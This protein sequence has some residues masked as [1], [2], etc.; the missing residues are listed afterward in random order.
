MKTQ[1]RRHP[2]G[3]GWGGSRA[4]GA[5]RAAALAGPVVTLVGVVVALVGA[6]LVVTGPASASTLRVA[7]TPGVAGTLKVEGAWLTAVSCTSTASCMAVGT[8]DASGGPSSFY[9]LTERWNGSAWSYV[10]SPTP[11]GKNGGGELQGVSCASASSCV[12]VGVQ[13]ALD[14]GEFRDEALAEV[15]NGTTWRMAS[16]P[17]PA[18]KTSILAGV[19]CVTARNCFAVG[20]AGSPPSQET[21]DLA[22]LAEQWNGTSWEIVSTPA[23]K[24]KGG[25]GLEAVSCASTASCMTG[26]YDHDYME[27]GNEEPVAESWNGT[28]W[29]QTSEPAGE[30]TVNGVF[31]GAPGRC[32]AVGAGYGGPPGTNPSTAAQTWNGT[33]WTVQP[34][35][36]PKNS[37]AAYL[38]A[39]SCATPAS[40]V[41]TGYW[42]SQSVENSL[43][44]AE[45]WNGSKWQIVT[46][47]SPGNSDELTGVACP[48][49]TDCLAVGSYVGKA[50]Q[51]TLAEQWNGTSWT[52]LKTPEGPS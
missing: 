42:F 16:V 23:L 14:Q 26:G 11:A 52:V 12:A 47:P 44:L 48:A 9:T 4:V 21:V 18:G 41:A 6:T 32:T 49:A 29:E 24:P 36:N 27:P 20:S 2:L 46:T 34:T 19:S 50:D 10:P 8:Y 22:T 3:A 39:V 43:N 15:W 30:G 38:Q 5:G 13:I 45:T 40:C 17:S 1:V 51:L 28:Q 25:R 7:A 37:F 31:C 33:K 35:P